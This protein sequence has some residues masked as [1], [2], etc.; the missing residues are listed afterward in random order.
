MKK[1]ASRP[2]PLLKW[3]RATRRAD[4]LEFEQEKKQWTK[5]KETPLWYH[6]K[7]PMPRTNEL[8]PPYCH[9]E[10]WNF[11]K[12]IKCQDTK[13]EAS[14]PRSLNKKRNSGGEPVIIKIAMPPPPIH[15]FEEWNFSKKI[16]RSRCEPTTNLYYNG[17]EGRGEP[18]N[19]PFQ[20]IIKGPCRFFEEWNFSKKINPQVRAD[21][22]YNGYEGR[23]E[24][25]PGKKCVIIKWWT[26]CPCIFGFLLGVS[27]LSQWFYRGW[28]LK[29]SWKGVQ[30]GGYGGFYHRTN[31]EHK[32][33][34]TWRQNHKGD[35]GRSRWGVPPLWKLLAMDSCKH[36][37]WC[38]RLD[39][40]DCT[41]DRMGCHV[42]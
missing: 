41:W 1:G 17:Y 2:H 16:K 28:W 19:I 36:Q 9:F 40:I 20:N 7:K 15:H 21:H 31:F 33:N 30:D 32:S 39:S 12:K 34:Q 22:Y 38:L 29:Y 25:T 27:P 11:S 18:T 13:D 14:R 6:E 8:A 4:P 23:G 26:L 35:R 10:E 42:L 24:P 37:T 5:E 3:I